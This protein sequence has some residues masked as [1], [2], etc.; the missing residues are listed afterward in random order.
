MFPT[1]N[2]GPGERAGIENEVVQF[3]ERTSRRIIAI[4]ASLRVWLRSVDRIIFS[5]EV[6]NVPDQKL[7]E[8]LTA[9]LL[10]TETKQPRLDD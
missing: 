7:I 5:K 2:Q 1:A 9:I 10:A 3:I 4:G 6:S 8:E